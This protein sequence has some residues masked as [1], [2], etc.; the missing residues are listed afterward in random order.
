MTKE[1]YYKISKDQKLPL[2]CP[3]L[4]NCA[5]YRHT[6]FFVGSACYKSRPKMNVENMQRMGILTS[7]DDI[8][9]MLDAGEPVTFIGGNSSFAIYNACPEFF[10][11]DHEHKIIGIDNLAVH[12][13]SYDEYYQGS[14]FKPGESKHY[15]ECAEYALYVSAKG[16]PK[17]RKPIRPQTRAELQK[18]INS[19]CPF[20]MDENVGHFQVHHID[21]NPENNCPE[22]LL[23]LCPICHSKITKGDLSRIEVEDKKRRLQNN[24]SSDPKDTQ[25]QA[26]LEANII[27]EL[28]KIRSAYFDAKWKER[29]TILDQIKKY[30]GH[31]G[32]F[33]AIEILQFL[34]NA[35]DQTR[36]GMP[37]PVAESIF[38][39]LL[40]FFP[41]DSDKEERHDIN[42]SKICLTIGFNLVYDSVIYLRKLSFIPIGLTIWKMVYRHALYIK[43]KHLLDT[44]AEYYDRLEETLKRSERNE[45]QNAIELVI[46]FRKDLDVSNLSYPI[47][48]NW[49][50]EIM[51]QEVTK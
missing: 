23:M 14:K 1:E 34:S 43:N 25:I 9:K 37:L 13:Y 19:R 48:P 29:A 30:S 7:K 44:I 6:A 40:L 47:W 38:H 3:C 39:L 17:S 18:E 21:E 31:S 33:A 45:L 46:I 51:K 32:N 16:K 35:S 10:L 15:T 11:H 8:E 22:N 27:I 36:G 5:R 42:L 12:Q 20:C 50:T 28:N 41:S 26:I 2:R 49:V 24:I 4:S